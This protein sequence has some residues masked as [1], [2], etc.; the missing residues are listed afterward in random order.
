VQGHSFVRFSFAVSTPQ[1]ETAIERMVPWM[2]SQ[3][4]S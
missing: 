4:V 1:I 3:R 2:R